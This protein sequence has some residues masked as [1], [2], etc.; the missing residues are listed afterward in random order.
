MERETSEEIS[1]LRLLSEQANARVAG[2]ESQVEELN[3]QLRDVCFP[4]ESMMK[5]M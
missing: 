4:C 2:L 3:Q 5:L 1:N